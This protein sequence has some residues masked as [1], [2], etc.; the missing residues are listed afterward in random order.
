MFESHKLSKLKIAKDLQELP[1]Y[2][3]GNDIVHSG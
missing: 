2:G 1:Q 3:P